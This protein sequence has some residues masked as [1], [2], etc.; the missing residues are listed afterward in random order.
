MNEIQFRLEKAYNEY[1]DSITAIGSSREI[2]LALTNAQQAQMWAL[3]R[4][5]NVS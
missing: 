2:S 1:I 5:K 3:E 4:I